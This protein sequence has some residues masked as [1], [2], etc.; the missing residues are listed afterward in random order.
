MDEIIEKIKYLCIHLLG[1]EVFGPQGMLQCGNQNA[2]G[3]QLF[4]PVG[5]SESPIW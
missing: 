1:L 3:V 5:V 4:K 2:L